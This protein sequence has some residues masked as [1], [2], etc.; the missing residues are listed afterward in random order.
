MNSAIESNTFLAGDVYFALGLSGVQVLAG[1]TALIAAIV[2][3]PR[4]ALAASFGVFGGI[5]GVLHFFEIR[6]L[7]FLV[8]FSKFPA[9]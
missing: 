7:V 5:V 8:W 9:G 2:Q 3:K 1:L 4:A 6:Y